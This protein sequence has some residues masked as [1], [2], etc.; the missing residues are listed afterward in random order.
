[1]IATNDAMGDRV[2]AGGVGF[3]E[4]FEDYVD[5]PN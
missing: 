3:G 2:K 4:N 1:L 5:Q